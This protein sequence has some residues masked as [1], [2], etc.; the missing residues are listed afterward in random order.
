[1]V[2]ERVGDADE[3]AVQ[4]LE[5]KQAAAEAQPPEQRDAATRLFLGGRHRLAEA[6]QALAAADAAPAGSAAAADA[7]LAGCQRLPQSFQAGCLAGLDPHLWGRQVG[8]EAWERALRAAP[9]TPRCGAARTGWTLKAPPRSR[10][11]S[12]R[13]AWP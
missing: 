6:R 13:P 12:T 11:S 5:A 2:V 7:W 1:M 3:L 8:L 4:G 9:S 10:P